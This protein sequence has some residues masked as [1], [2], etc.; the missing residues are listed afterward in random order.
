MKRRTLAVVVALAVSGPALGL[1]LA[2]CSGDKELP[3]ANA[4]SDQKMNEVAD[5]RA[6]AAAYGSIPHRRTRYDREGARMS[7]AEN[8]YLAS[9]FRHVDLAMVQRVRLA[10]RITLGGGQDE[11]GLDYPVILGGLAALQPPSSL[12][13]MHEL[14][15]AAV[16]EQQ[17]VLADWKRSG[18]TTFP[19]HDSRVH[20]ASSKL[21]RAYSLLMSGVPGAGTHNK[22]AFFDYLCALDFI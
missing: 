14:V 1:A 10:E 11:H 16:V 15:V 4:L 7:G 6:I 13:E 12:R 2:Q 9:F 3:P 18:K 8:D 22:Q 17:A 5:E 21:R 20:Q 19:R